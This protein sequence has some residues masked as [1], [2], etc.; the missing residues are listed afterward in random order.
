MTEVGRSM[1]K[2]LPNQGLFSAHIMGLTQFW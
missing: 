1:G 2:A